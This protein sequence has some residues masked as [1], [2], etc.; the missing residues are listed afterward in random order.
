MKLKITKEEQQEIT[1]IKA[2]YIAMLDEKRSM[3]AYTINSVNRLGKLL[4]IFYALADDIKKRGINVGYN[5]GGG[6]SGN[7]QNDSVKLLENYEVDIERLKKEIE[8]YRDENMKVVSFGEKKQ[9]DFRKYEQYFNDEQLSTSKLDSETIYKEL[10]IK[11]FCKDNGISPEVA[12]A[13]IKQL[14]DNKATQEEVINKLQAKA[15][16]LEELEYARDNN[17]EDL[18]NAVV[19]NNFKDDA[20]RTKEEMKKL[21]V[22]ENQVQ[23]YY[24]TGEPDATEYLQGIMYYD[25][26]NFRDDE[27]NA[28]KL[29]GC[30]YVN[31]E[32]EVYF[33]ERV[34]QVAN[35]ID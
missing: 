12:N 34:K 14:R 6:Q 32:V 33:N 11:N 20:E 7:K 35:T 31:D 19:F 3:N 4:E 26:I 24:D 30:K 8:N 29:K 23:G 10:S 28:E 17:T 13:Y 21:K 9:Y 5:N 22:N 2:H 15:D 1:L 18:V 16:V 25:F 27:N